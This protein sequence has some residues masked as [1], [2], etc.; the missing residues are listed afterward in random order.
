MNL[1]ITLSLVNDVETRWY[2]L[3]TLTHRYNIPFF[4][5]TYIFLYL[6]FRNSTYEMLKRFLE[7]KPAIVATLAIRNFDVQLVHADWQLME[8]LFF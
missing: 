4:K 1:A 5:N 8:K 7:L 3:I 6:Y 2:V